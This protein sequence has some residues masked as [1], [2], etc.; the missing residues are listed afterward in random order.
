MDIV[1]L[2]AA[3]KIN[4]GLDIVG[5]REDGYHEIR[6]VM[7]SVNIFDR[8]MI[9]KNGKRKIT[10]KA[11]LPHIPTDERNL[12]WKAAALFC[13]EFGFEEGVDIELEKKIP[14]QAGL[15]GGSA[16]A[17]AVLKGM[18]KLYEIEVCENRLL[19]LAA[20]IG[21]D[22]PYCLVGGTAL[23]EGI[24]E[25]I[26]HLKK[27]PEAFA[28]ILKPGFSLST[29]RVFERLSMKEIERRGHA[30]IDAI[31]SGIEK[32]DLISA[33]S[34]IKNVLEYSVSISYPTIEKI[35][36]DMLLYR[37]IGSSMSGSGSAVFG[38]FDNRESAKHCMERLEAEEGIYRSCEF[39]LAELL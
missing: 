5:K 11:D 22:V 14:V 32:G 25:K 31:I 29:K 15:G 38:I 19:R 37:A 35:K 26:R 3:A 39:F 16:D 21:A 20:G 36:G 30:D 1:C 28:L 27:F 9:K 24:G 12:A 23:C 8:I 18:A 2:E 33:A 17:A 10:L 6:T 7:Q 13:R 4:I 34:N